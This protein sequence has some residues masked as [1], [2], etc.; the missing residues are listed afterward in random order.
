[1]STDLRAILISRDPHVIDVFADRFRGLGVITEN[2]HDIQVAKERL[3]QSKVEAIVVDFDSLNGSSSPFE[4]IRGE[5]S[6]RGAV[7]IAIASSSRTTQLAIRAGARFILQ[8]PFIPDQVSKAIHAAYTLMLQD[9]RKYFRVTAVLDVTIF[10]TSGA[11]VHCTTINLARNGIALNT[12]M[13]L[14]N[15]ESLDLVFPIPESEVLIRA[16]A[17]VVWDDRHGKTGLRFEWM[18]KQYEKPLHTWLDEQ[19]LAELQQP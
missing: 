15:G 9:R 19:Y 17:T 18:D 12:P 8:R 2:M 7:L 10:R 16:Q 14:D 5:K 1:M 3:L 11:K 6:N 13:A 4:P